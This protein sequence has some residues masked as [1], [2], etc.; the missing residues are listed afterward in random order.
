MSKFLSEGHWEMQG[1]SDREG[2]RK[3]MNAN[4]FTNRLAGAAK[5]KKEEIKGKL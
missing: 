1:V 5:G 4:M 3:T 2:I